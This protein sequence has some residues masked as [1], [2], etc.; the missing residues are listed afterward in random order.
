[1]DTTSSNGSGKQRI[2]VIT[3][4]ERRRR[5]SLQDKERLLAECD[6]PGETVS[7]VARRNGIS[8]SMLFKWRRLREEGALMAVKHEEEV[9]P[10]SEFKQAQAR[11]RELERLL[12]RKTLETE[13][14][15]DAIEIAKQKK[16][17]S[18]A[19]LFPREDTL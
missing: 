11:I 2:E 5:W 18:R 14:L 15:K 9:V 1:M 8:P 12:G 6:Q 4:V 13:I 17:I 3:S 10:L 16:W 19:P 7:S